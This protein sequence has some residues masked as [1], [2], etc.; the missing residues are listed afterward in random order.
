MP[1]EIQKYRKHVEKF[2][3]SDQEKDE[4]IC[5]VQSIMQNFVDRAFGDDPVQLCHDPDNSKDALDEPVVIDLVAREIS[6][7]DITLTDTFNE[8]KKKGHA[9]KDD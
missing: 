1:H 4:L 9:A 3:L 5:V 6:R 8:N 2:D 7:S